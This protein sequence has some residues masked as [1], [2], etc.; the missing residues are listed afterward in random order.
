VALGNRVFALEGGD[1]PGSSFPNAI[2]FL[3]VR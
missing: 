3:D 2:D 1:H